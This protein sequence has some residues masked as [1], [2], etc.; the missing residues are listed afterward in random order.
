M[1]M[2]SSSAGKVEYILQSSQYD[3]LKEASDEIANALMAQPDVSKVH[4]NS[5]KRSAG[6]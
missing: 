1:S 5:G 6:C 2:M 3:E 4:T